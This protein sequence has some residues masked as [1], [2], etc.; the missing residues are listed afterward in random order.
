MLLK[1]KRNG[2]LKGQA[3]TDDRKQRPVSSKEDATSPTESIE[4][5]LITY[6]IDTYKRIELVIVDV[7]RDLLMEDPR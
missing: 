3:C 5:V 4:V 6:I 7:P 2:G 1:E